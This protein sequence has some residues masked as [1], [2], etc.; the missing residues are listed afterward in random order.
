MCFLR[1]LTKIDKLYFLWL[2]K[3]ADIDE[4]FDID[5]YYK[6]KEK[7]E[8]IKEL[9]DK[10][11]DISLF[12]KKINDC[13]IQDNILKLLTNE[14]LKNESQ[15]VYSMLIQNNIKIITYES[16]DYPKKLKR[17]KKDCIPFCILYSGN[18]NLNKINILLFFEDYFTKFA[19]NIT[20][21]FA[22]IINDEKANVFSKYKNNNIISI[23]VKCNSF[24]TRNLSLNIINENYKD[25]TFVFLSKEKYLYD[26]ITNVLD[27]IIIIEARY[28]KEIVDLVNIFV[29]NGKDIYVV[30]SNI[31]RKNSY[32]SN[33]LIKQGADIILNK[34]DLKFILNGIIC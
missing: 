10:S 6:L 33:Y 34:R 2:Q 20:Y 22:K 14:K 12:K 31:F 25:N 7:F 8:S 18:I 13:F 24:C 29:E 9:Y 28:E 11:K 3:I 27:A 30:P 21:Y 23:Q 15:Q 16:E 4:E 1:R 17:A 32:L 26:F 5:I 19:R